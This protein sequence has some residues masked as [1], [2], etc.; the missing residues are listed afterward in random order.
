MS[1]DLIP[2]IQCH[3]SYLATNS[4]SGIVQKEDVYLQPGLE[5]WTYTHC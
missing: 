2:L 3:Q 4:V 5:F 1:Y